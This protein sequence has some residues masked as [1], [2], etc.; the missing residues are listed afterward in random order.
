MN[1]TSRR[2]PCVSAL[3]A[4]VFLSPVV[5]AEEARRIEEI[6]VTA[7]KRESTVSD[8]SISITAMNEE[9]LE[10]MGIQGADEMVNFVPAMTRNNYDLVIR[11]IGRNFR[12]LGGDPGVAS[13]YNNV[14][15]PDFG[16]AASENALYDLARVEVLRGPQGTLYGRNSIGGAVNYITN[17]PTYHMEGELRAVVGNYDSREFYGVLSGPIIEDTLAYRLVGVT[18][19]RDGV[20]D[21]WGGGG[22]EDRDSINDQNFALTLLWDVSEKISMKARVNDRRSLRA[23]PGGHWFEA[24][25]ASA[26]VRTPDTSRFRFLAGG[27]WMPATREP[28]RL[29]TRYL[30]PGMVHGAAPVSTLRCTPTFS[31]RN[32]VTLHLPDSMAVTRT[33]LPATFPPTGP[34]RKSSITWQAPSSSTGSSATP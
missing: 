28:C 3:A 34:A 12:S 29:P 6:V 32:T 2:V 23:I 14:Y 15:S 18:R 22:A 25:P 11:G 27:R 10:D 4:L 26:R 20:L 16:I 1:D 5:V 30:E 17:D 33:T 19:D 24:G 8:T 13:Y 7:E 9:F 31:T 21:A